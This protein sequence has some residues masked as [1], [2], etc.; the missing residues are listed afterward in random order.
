MIAA[1]LAAINEQKQMFQSNPMTKPSGTQLQPIGVYAK[2]DF[3][4]KHKDRLLREQRLSGIKAIDGFM[5]GSDNN[6]AIN[7]HKKRLHITDSL[8]D[9]EDSSFPS[10][11][12]ETIKS[13]SIGR[14]QAHLLKDNLIFVGHPSVGVTNCDNLSQVTQSGTTSGLKRIYTISP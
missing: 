1:E 14:K 5:E 9:L 10:S 12:Y 6:I 3:I 8:P 7:Y 4:Q 13:A 2:V 11:G